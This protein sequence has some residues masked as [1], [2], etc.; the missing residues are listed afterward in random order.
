LGESFAD[1][2]GGSCASVFLERVTDE[3][4][5]A[6]VPRVTV[7]AYAAA[8]EVGHLLLGNEAHTPQGL[9]KAQWGRSEYQAMSQNHFQFSPE[10]LQA[11]A[12]RYGLSRSANPDPNP[13]L[14]RTP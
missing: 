14:A 2:N 4:A 1:R 10:Q 6:N 3:A 9:M 5:E 11:L 8:H 12:R 7:L 13:A